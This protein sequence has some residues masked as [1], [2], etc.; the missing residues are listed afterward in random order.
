MKIL[1]IGPPRSGTTSLI[2]SLGEV[3][4][5]TLIT[6]PFN[7]NLKNHKI[8]SHPINYDDGVIVKMITAQVPLE[9]NNGDWKF[10][11]NF[12]I[13]EINKFDYVILLNRK[14]LKE[15]WESYINLVYKNKINS[16][17]HSSWSQL[18]DDI[19]SIIDIGHKNI[20]KYQRDVIY[21]IS[22]LLNINIS[23]YEELYGTD[24]TI[25]LKLIT[26]WGL[27]LDNNILNDLLHPKFKYRKQ[28]SLI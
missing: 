23:W 2:R 22:S 26:S 1:I 14:N 6:E 3:T 19:D 15:H 9:Y 16:Q 11:K 4:K 12:I 5:Y 13:D 24:R 10:F 21:D 18:P 27:G 28:K 17:P 8:Y 25:S 7:Y 20:F